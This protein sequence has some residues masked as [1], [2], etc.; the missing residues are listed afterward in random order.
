[1]IDG[2]AVLISQNLKKQLVDSKY[3][4]EE[5]FSK[6]PYGWFVDPD[7]DIIKLP[8]FFEIDLSKTEKHIYFNYGQNNIPTLYVSKNVLNIILSL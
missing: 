5:K 3:C 1:M 6:I 2:S 4:N 7:T 8:D